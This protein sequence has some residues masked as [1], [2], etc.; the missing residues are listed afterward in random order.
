M[1]PA[2]YLP[3]IKCSSCGDEIEI[4][5]MGDH[6]CGK[7]PMS[8]GGKGDLNNP[9]TLRQ[10]HAV[11]EKPATMPAPVQYPSQPPAQNHAAPPQTRVRAPTL[12][13]GQQPGPKPSRSA[14]PRINPDAANRPFLAPQPPRS[15]TPLSPALS[16][17]SGSSG[18]SRPSYNRSAT[19][20]MP[21][22]FDFR[23]PSPELTGSFDCAFPPFPTSS[24]P[25]SRPGTSNG[26]KTPTNSD[27]APSRSGMKQERPLLAQPAPTRPDM[28]RS[29]LAGGFTAG[30]NMVSRAN[31]LKNGPFEA[32]RRK[33]SKDEQVPPLPS[34]MD[35]RR[36]SVPSI[37]SVPED[38]P[39]R[40]PTA[41]SI[42]SQPD[43]SRKG[44]PPRPARPSDEDVMSPTFMNKFS[45]EPVSDMPSTFSPSQPPVPLRS[46]DRSKTFPIRQESTDESGPAHSLHRMPSEPAMR[47]GRA[48]RP[49]LTAGSGTAPSQ[50]PQINPP[51]RSASRNETRIDY[52]MHD[53]PPVPK[54]VQQISHA[55]SESS[56]S[57]G[58][59]HPSQSNSSS[60]PSPVTSAASSVDAFSPLRDGA[61]YGD[62]EKLR[63]AGLNVKALPKPHPGMRAELPAQ[64]SPPR[65]L[66]Q[67]RSN[68][69]GSM[70]ATP[71]KMP[72]VLA[73]PMESPIDPRRA[74]SPAFSHPED[75]R[76]SQERRV[77]PP[78]ADI[79][80]QRAP[81][82]GSL[83]L[84][85]KPINDDYDPYR[86]QSPLPGALTFSP[87]ETS[88]SP[89]DPFSTPGPANTRSHSPNPPQQPLPAPPQAPRS[90]PQ[91]RPGPIRRPT[92]GGVKPS[93]RGCNQTIEG[94]SVKAADGR[95]TGRWHK[96]CFTCRTCHQPFATADFYVIDNQPYCEQHYH[97]KNGSLCAGCNRGIEGQYLETSS[98]AVSG[99]GD[100]K[101]HPRCFTCVQCRMVLS[102]DYFE[103]TGKVYCERHALQAMRG[104]A[105]MG[106]PGVGPPAPNG[107]G[108]GNGGL[109]PTDRKGLM[110][111]RRT[112]KLMMM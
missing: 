107:M 61:G 5:A 30:E 68:E 86:A 74:P 22:L 35:G 63:V 21:S 49:T 6:I 32:S 82:P 10:L 28:P 37:A 11:G 84:A 24:T 97:E 90:Q 48:R 88:A 92:A 25:G 69:S 93:C 85:P 8:P 62:D 47:P 102:D 39:P 76:P 46:S 13:S 98:S 34:H 33:S 18:S 96:Q 41:G 45:S 38:L 12:G 17:R 64:R 70:P 65:G 111:E 42:Y 36:P 95:L 50:V 3:A 7:A 78:A 27:R 58:S 77:T 105:R 109:N 104:Q 99:G 71:P 16:A 60:G 75:R 44:P 26:R 80:A 101:Y 91:P 73:P 14:P 108:A 52:R 19:S 2:S 55:P 112:T 110:A 4:A 40:P 20:P 53:A 54:A 83:N 31:T 43:G 103:I 57:T 100:R 66:T 79:T 9:F 94:K 106:G 89:R 56:S 81:P 87:S 72:A 15:N 59:A 23:P 51:P 29:P 1:R 67:T